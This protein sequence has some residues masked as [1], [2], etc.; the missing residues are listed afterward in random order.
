M[1]FSLLDM[2]RRESASPAAWEEGR[3]REGRGV[4]GEAWGEEERMNER[5]VRR[6]RSGRSSEQAA[7][8]ERR[9]KRRRNS[10]R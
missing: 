9:Q 10:G 6:V 7:S 5:E 8:S 1:G 4:R 3:E 2:R